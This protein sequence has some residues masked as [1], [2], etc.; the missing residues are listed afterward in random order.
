MSSIFI[1]LLYIYYTNFL[2]W[3]DCASKAWWA[4]SRQFREHVVSVEPDTINKYIRGGTMGPNIPLFTTVQQT[5]FQ[6]P[7]GA[8]WMATL[9]WMVEYVELCKKITGVDSNILHSIYGVLG[10]VGMLTGF[11]NAAAVDEY[12][13]KLAA[14][15]DL[16]PKF[17]EA[18]QYALAGTVLQ[19]HIVKIA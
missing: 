17:L 8:D 6:L 13:S 5:Q 14:N 18:G 2:T 11:Q 3:V 7:Q 1:Y 12:R 9:K 16:L 15:P 19:R 10:G 4:A